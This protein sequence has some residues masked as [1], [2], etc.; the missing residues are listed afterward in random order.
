MNCQLLNCERECYHP[1]DYL[2]SNALGYSTFCCY[3][4]LGV[5]QQQIEETYH[6][7]FDESLDAIKLSKSLVDDIKIAESERY[8]P[9]EYLHPYEPSQ[10]YQPNNNNVIFIEPYEFPEPFVLETEVSTDQNDHNDQ[11]D[12]TAQT[13]EIL[14]DD[15]S[16][17]SNHTNDEQI[18]DNLSNTE[19]IH[20]PANL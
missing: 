3:P 12:K 5:L 18:I 15:Q 7:I 11:N 9:D 17:H 1:E 2:L 10:R 13:G 20:I 14:K 6:I 8:P 16:E 19:D 4:D